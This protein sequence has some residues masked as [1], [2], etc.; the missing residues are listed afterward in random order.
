MKWIYRGLLYLI[1][2][3]SIIITSVIYLTYSPKG[4]P[5]LW[6]HLTPYIKNIHIQ[7]IEGILAS[8][9]IIKGL[10]IKGKSSHFYIDHVQAKWSLHHFLA[11]GILPIE[12][13]EINQLTSIK[14]NNPQLIQ[15]PRKPGFIQFNI[16]NL[17]IN[18][19]TTLH[20]DRLTYF[21]NT[22]AH[23]QFNQTGLHIDHVKTHS[24]KFTFQASGFLKPQPKIP[25]EMLIQWQSI[26]NQ[27]KATGQGY[28]KGDFY[29][30]DI[31][32]LADKP[33]K[34]TAW[35]TGHLLPDIHFNVTGKPEPTAFNISK[36][37]R[38]QMTNGHI[39]YIGSPYQYKLT[40]DATFKNKHLPT[41]QMRLEGSGIQKKL[42]LTTFRLESVIGTIQGNGTL[43]I[44]KS[45]SGNINLSSKALNP[46]KHWP[47]LEGQLSLNT[48]AN[49]SNRYNHEFIHIN[50]M[51]LIGNIR[52]TPF[53][54]N[55][56]FNKQ[57][58]IYNIKQLKLQTGSAKIK[59]TGEMS[60]N[61]DLSWD[62]D[63][64]DVSVLAP[65]SKGKIISK[66]HINGNLNSLVGKGTLEIDDFESGQYAFKHIKTTL[67]WDSTD[68]KES[69][70][71][72]KINHAKVNAI[73]FNQ[74]LFKMI[75]QQ[76]KHRITLFAKHE[77]GD[78]NLAIN[79]NR[80]LQQ[81]DGII[82]KLN[83]NLDQLGQWENSEQSSLNIDKHAMR[84]NKICLKQQQMNICG[85]LQ[86]SKSKGWKTDIT[87]N[88]LSTKRIKSWIPQHIK[89]IGKLNGQVSATHHQQQ[90][91]LDYHIKSN[92]NSVFVN[93]KNQVVIDFKYHHID[94]KGQIRNHEMDSSIDAKFQGDNQ[95]QSHIKWILP[96]SIS[97]WRDTAV[98]GNI[99][100]KFNRVDWIPIF[101][102]ELHNVNANFQTAI[103]LSGTLHKPH[104]QGNIATKDGR[105][106]ILPMGISLE[107]IQLDIRRKNAQQ[108][109]I[110]G[111]ANSGKG[112]V[113]IDG[114][115]PFDHTFHYPMTL[116]ISGN[117]FTIIQLPSYHIEISPLLT[118]TLHQEKIVLK[119]DLNI[120]NSNIQLQEISPQ[121]I[122]LSPDVVILDKAEK[123][124]HPIKDDALPD[125]KQNLNASIN[126]ILNKKTR[127]I[128]FG[129]NAVISGKVALTESPGQSTQG[130]GT[131]I[132]E[133]GQ[134]AAFGQNL[135]IEE[136]RLMF[137]GPIDNPNINII[138]YRE[139]EDV[140]AYIKIT[141]SLKNSQSILYSDPPMQ[142]QEI[143]SYLLLGR[144][145]KAASAEEGNALINAVN[146]IGLKGGELVAQKIGAV[147]G[148]DE[149]TVK[150]G[151]ANNEASLFVGKYLSPKLYARY[152]IGL[153]KSE[154]RELQLRY[155][156]NK[157]LTLEAN[158]GETKALE[159]W[160]NI[161]YE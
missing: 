60:Q 133:E 8:G 58:N 31:A 150:A 148:L 127:F 36:K 38:L 16:Q 24:N 68:N 77:H 18:Q 69:N 123:P 119:G 55:T 7:K 59:V 4:I 154:A 142:Q 78:I 103:K 17:H 1:L 51:K 134:Y 43:T 147:M 137:A 21:T 108:I 94:L 149:V 114:T 140:K 63:I 10:V 56:I 75:G 116:N 3:S 50:K 152:G 22:T 61:A 34:M 143:L 122:Q 146:S 141:G 33:F 121:S 14:K 39:L 96:S 74:I 9:I 97:K 79:G 144:P 130:R 72:I 125:F 100:I 37:Q 2:F 35:G 53:N 98:N 15:L 105:V 5:W 45:I 88:D 107:N 47:T 101:Y 113:K 6:A 67:D 80:K 71:T 109:L 26:F 82:E 117:N 44:N 62:L 92:H 128:G 93:V 27:Q 54:L 65:E 95:L 89:W 42:A 118:L 138:A 145:L 161:E 104:L 158:Q 135:T 64:P 28:F 90:F 139:I 49:F 32:H 129:L 46:G 120:P 160:Y 115:I 136:G 157:Q 153:L 66:G 29:H 159:I 83:I 132:F 40:L 86:W 12:H 25:F 19:I 85:T 13:L 124:A 156:V 11:T 20:N 84:I 81:W 23:G 70:A 110:K 155:K 112:Q 99:N 106:Q 111:H 102:P 131:L 52:G 30:F 76:K 151:Q 73:Q 41:L 87:L 91:K 57:K 48:K 126:L